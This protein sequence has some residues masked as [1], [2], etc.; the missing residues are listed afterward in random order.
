[1]RSRRA[2]DPPCLEV[3]NQSNDPHPR[4]GQHSIAMKEEHRKRC[5]GRREPAS[6]PVQVVPQREHSVE[7][8]VVDPGLYLAQ[9]V[10]ADQRIEPGADDERRGCQQDPVDGVR[11]PLVRSKIDSAAP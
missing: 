1:M 6:F 4:R 7:Q 9:V 5:F 11:A 8:S 3:R 2:L 10:A